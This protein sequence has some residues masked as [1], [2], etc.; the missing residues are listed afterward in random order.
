M[1]ENSP[2]LVSYPG[3]NSPS[4]PHEEGSPSD[5]VMPPQM[6]ADQ[7]SAGGNNSFKWSGHDVSRATLRIC[8]TGN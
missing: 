5:A 7:K 2:N 1:G 6:L 8:R 3:S 4:R